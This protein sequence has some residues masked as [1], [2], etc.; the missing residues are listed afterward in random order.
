MERKSCS[1]AF[2]NAEFLIKRPMFLKQEF[3]IGEI[4]FIIL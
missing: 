2:A 3:L 4:Q 1:E